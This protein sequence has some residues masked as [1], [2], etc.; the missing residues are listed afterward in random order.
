M[1][2]KRGKKGVFLRKERIYI[3]EGVNPFNGGDFHKERVKG[4]CFQ[5]E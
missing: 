1:P 4:G 5:G 3:L 2:E